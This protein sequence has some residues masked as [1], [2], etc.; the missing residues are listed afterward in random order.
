MLYG[1][2]VPMKKYI[3]VLADEPKDA[4]KSAANV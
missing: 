3:N 1:S 4:A 2:D